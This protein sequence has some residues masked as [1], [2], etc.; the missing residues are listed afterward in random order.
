MPHAIETGDIAQL[1]AELFAILR[2]KTAVPASCMARIGSTAGRGTDEQIRAL[3]HFFENLGLAFQI[4]GIF[5]LLE[6]IL[7]E[8]E[9]SFNMFK[10]LFL[11]CF[12][13]LSTFRRRA[14]SNWVQRQSK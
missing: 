3:G 1:R 6:T 5:F 14:Q 4:I 9:A 11:L 13:F 2:L 10:R 12:S 8:G 7:H